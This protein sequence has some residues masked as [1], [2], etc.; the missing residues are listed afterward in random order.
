MDAD[1]AS[2][3]LPV[4]AAVATVVYA[5]GADGADV[6]FRVVVPAAPGATVRLG[7]VKMLC[8]P[9]GAVAWSPKLEGVHGALSL[10]FTETV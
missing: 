5:P 8:Q 3:G 10:F 1:A 9:T 7:A 2:L 6:T 4:F